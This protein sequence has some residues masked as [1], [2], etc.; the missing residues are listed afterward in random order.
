MEFTTFQNGWIAERVAKAKGAGLS[1]VLILLLLFSVAGVCFAH[2]LDP[3]AIPP[4]VYNLNGFAIVICWIAFPILAILLGIGVY[5][6]SAEMPPHKRY[7]FVEKNVGLMFRPR[8][9]L[10]NILLPFQKTIYFVLV[11]ALAADG[12][13]LTPIW[14]GFCFLLIAAFM[15]GIKSNCKEMIATLTEQNVKEYET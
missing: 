11:I 1:S 6:T 7:D 12:Y 9:L 8:Q 15:K 2:S 14:F 3:S 10:D 5:W 13:V 4:I